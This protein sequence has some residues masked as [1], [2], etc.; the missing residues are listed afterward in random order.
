[1]RAITHADLLA[2]ARM[3]W[4]AAPASRGEVLHTALERAH[5]A[6]LYRKRTGRAHPF[7][8]NGSLAGFFALHGQ[9]PPEPCLSAPGFLEAMAEAM[10]A[11][12]EWRARQT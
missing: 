4:R 12:L 7:W 11:L 6:D 3:L 5:A 1:M 10:D 2:C 9:L 8:G